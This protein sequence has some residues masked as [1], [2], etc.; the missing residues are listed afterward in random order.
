M[1]LAPQK[2]TPPYVSLE[3]GDRLTR[4]EF[5]RRYEASGIPRAELV[6]GVV[7]VGSPVRAQSHGE[8]V[9]AL[10]GWL[11]TYWASHSGLRVAHNT[12]VLL[13]LDNELQPDICMW[14]EGGSSRVNDDGYIEAAPE[15]VLEIAASSASIDM[16]AKKAVY[17]RNGVREYLVWRVLDRDV[18]RFVLEDGEYI[19]LTPDTRGWLEGREFPGLCLPVKELLEGNFAAVLAA[20][21]A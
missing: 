5:H 17:R 14:R 2:H 18:D 21:Q 1:V 12:T 10:G 4:A 19:A 15:L 11:G 9:G 8:P 7:H 3:N 20:A 13:D 6:E 16:H